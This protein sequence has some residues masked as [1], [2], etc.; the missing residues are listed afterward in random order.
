MLDLSF[1]IDTYYAYDF[2][3]PKVDRVFTTQPTKHD[4]PSINLAHVDWKLSKD[5]V[6]SR[7]ALHAGDSVE[8][9]AT[10]EPGAEK[11]IQESFIGYK[12]N[13]KLWLDGGIFF[14]HIGAETWVSKDNWNYTRALSAD[15]V[16]YYSSGLRF[17]YEESSSRSYQ[18]HI[19]NG[20]QNISENNQAKS[21]GFQL[22]NNFKSNTSFIYN[23][24]FGDEEVI[25]RKSRFRSYHNFILKHKLSEIW[26]SI[27]TFDIGQQSQQIKSGTDLW[28]VASLSLKYI[29]DFNRSLNFRIEHY[30]DRH[31]ANV[32]TDSRKGFVV[33]NASIN[34]DQLLIGQVNWRTEYRFYFSNERIYPTNRPRKAIGDSFIVSSLAV[35]F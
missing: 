12:L 6:R 7:L 35:D 3:R 34:Y 15:F 33:S 14:G 22:I 25:S 30:H 5:K 16:P 1:F 19:I 26:D 10:T 4:S 27:T 23:N 21:L 31:E 20:W 11:Y 2:N 32:S 13:E 9:N 8:R 24:F 18:F 28:W 17:T 29:L